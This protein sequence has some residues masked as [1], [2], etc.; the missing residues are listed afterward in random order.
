M[1]VFVKL[2]CCSENKA[3]M[4]LVVPGSADFRDW[5]RAHF[6]GPELLV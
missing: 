1:S 3:T 5:C 4:A 2:G 6:F